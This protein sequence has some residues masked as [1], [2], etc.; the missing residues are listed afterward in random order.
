VKGAG[1]LIDS[2]E[3]T[4]PTVPREPKVRRVFR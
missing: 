4:V 1:E 2:Q 3:G